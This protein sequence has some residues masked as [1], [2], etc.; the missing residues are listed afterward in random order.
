[1]LNGD[2]DLAQPQTLPSSR[3]FR[4]PSRSYQ[5]SFDILHA[6]RA[7]T[8]KWPQLVR[9]RCPDVATIH[10]EVAKDVWWMMIEDAPGDDEG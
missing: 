7:L 3:H 4:R 2:V 8:N 10:S 9:R 6:P 1:V 5:N